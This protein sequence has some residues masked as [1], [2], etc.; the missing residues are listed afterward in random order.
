MAAFH[1]ERNC[2]FSSN[3]QVRPHR[4]GAGVWGPTKVTLSRGTRAAEARPSSPATASSHVCDHPLMAFEA[5]DVVRRYNAVY[6]GRDVAMVVREAMAGIDRGNPSAVS[7]ALP[8]RVA[9]DP[10]YEL[11][12]Q[13]IVRDLSGAGSVEGPWHGLE[14][15]AR[16]WLE[17][18]GVWERYVYEVTAYRE[19]GDWVLTV[20][21]TQARNRDGLEL[22][23]RVFQLWRV[24]DGRIAVMRGFLSEDEAL[25][26]AQ[27][28]P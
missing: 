1:A 14:G 23:M 19:L 8:D 26:A 3:S 15:V 10:T 25:R 6:E 9:A 5:V 12:H 27:S 28:P 7:A 2:R 13:E 24:R 20:A 21:D 22:E 18:A 16:Y 17:W 11:L 4:L